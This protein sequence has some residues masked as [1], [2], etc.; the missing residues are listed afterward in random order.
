MAHENTAPVVEPKLPAAPAEPVAVEPKAGAPVPE[1]PPAAEGGDLPDELMRI[2]ALQGLLVGQPAAVSASIAD[3]AKRPEGQL[4]GKNAGPL[5]AAGFGF[6][7]TKA[8]DL[9]VLFNQRYVHG[10]QLKAADLA[11]TLQE[12]AP[13]FDAV[14][15][16]LSQAGADH[17][18]MNAEAGPEGFAAAPM[19]QAPTSSQ[20]APPPASVPRQ[21]QAARV[22]NLTPGGPT[23]GARPGAGRILNS[24][25]KPVQ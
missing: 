9:G 2:P 3:F 22:K 16:Q 8:G 10:E 11:G 6:Y 14:N 21:A 7:R 17:P 4:I 25:L 20:V 12:L 24:I 18:M 1:A 15:Q 13:P 23:S 5:T 19:P